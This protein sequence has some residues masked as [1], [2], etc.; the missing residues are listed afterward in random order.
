MESQKKWIPAFESVLYKSQCHSEELPVL[1]S[2]LLRRMEGDE[3]SPNV[4]L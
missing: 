3:E 2:S 1:R 4:I